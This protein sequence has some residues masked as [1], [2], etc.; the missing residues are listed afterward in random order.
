MIRRCTHTLRVILMLAKLQLSSAMIY[1]ASFWGAFFADSTL[2]LVQ[3]LFFRVIAAN[4]NIGDWNAH[5]L[6]VFVGTFTAL[7]GLYMATYFFGIIRLPNQIRTG[8]LDLAIVKPVNTLLYVTLG[9]I[10]LGSLALFLLGLGIVGYGASQLGAITLAGAL[11]FA[12]VFLLMY[13]LMYALMLCLRTA[14]FWLTRVNAF[15]QIENTLVEFSFKLPAPAITGLW[16]VLLFV[17]LPY[18]LMANMPSQ[19]LY[20]PFGLTEWA[21]SLGATISFLL[22]AIWLW[23]RGMQRY[24]SASS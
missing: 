21:Y 3:L 12:L 16:K 9:N 5:H 4:G 2:F 14:S 22:L 18:G 7:D 15:S 24:D 19:A 1:R 13:T 6:T 17:V 8:N 20:G 10:N 23:N 11:Q